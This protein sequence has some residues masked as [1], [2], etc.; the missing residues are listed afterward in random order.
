MAVGDAELAA[1]G[2]RHQAQRTGPVDAPTRWTVRHQRHVGVVFGQGAEVFQFKVHRVI[3][4]LDRLAGPLINKMQVAVSELDG[5][6]AYRERFAVGVVRRWLAGRQLE[7]LGQIERAVLV[8]QQFGLRLVQLYVGQV[9]GFG[10]QAVDLQVGVKTVE[11]DLFLAGFAHSKAP[12]R[13]LEAEGIELQPVEFG[14][15]GGV[16]G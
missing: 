15:D 5:V 6:D 1:G 4:K 12:Q 14:R 13:Q 2:N 3:Q 10:P 8:E 9:Q 16:V 11:P 7:Q